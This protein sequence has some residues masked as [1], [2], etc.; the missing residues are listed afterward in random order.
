MSKM[1]IRRARGSLTSEATAVRS[2]FFLIGA[3][4]A[5]GGFVVGRRRARGLT[6]EQSTFGESAHGS[7]P[8]TAEKTTVG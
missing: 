1:A 5:A 3:A 4:G 2:L 6:Q 8:R 7:E